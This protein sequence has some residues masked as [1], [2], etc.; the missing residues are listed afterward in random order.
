[1]I[2]REKL[3]QWLNAFPSVTHVEIDGGGTPVVRV[4]TTRA[5]VAEDIKTGLLLLNGWE[6]VASGSNAVS[7]VTLVRAIKLAGGAAR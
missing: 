1:V 4:E 3:L 2:D 7:L 6:G 5:E